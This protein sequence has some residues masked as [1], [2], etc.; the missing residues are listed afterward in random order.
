MRRNHCSSS[1]SRTVDSQRQHLPSSTCSFASTVWQRSHQ[2]TIGLPAIGEAALEHRDEE[3]LL[4]AIVRGIA[5]RELAS[6]VVAE[7]HAPQLIPH[8]GDVVARPGRR[9]RPALDRRVLRRHAEGV[10][11]DRVQDVEAAHASLARDHVADRV[12]ADVAHVDAAGRIRKHLEAVE[13]RTGRVGADLVGTLLG[14]ARLPALLDGMRIVAVLHAVE[15][16]ARAA[17]LWRR[18]SRRSD[19]ARRSRTSE[20][21][22]CRSAWRSR[23]PRRSRRSPGTSRRQSNS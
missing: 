5:G 4:P 2:L 14:P 12:V 17:A 8:V 20:T 6:P 13:L 11:A 22:R 23:W 9:M 19:R 7:P 15:T 16:R 3:A 18:P 21:R 1:R 10:P